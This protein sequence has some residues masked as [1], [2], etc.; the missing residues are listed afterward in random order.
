MKFLFP[1]LSRLEGRYFRRF[2]FPDVGLCNIFA[3]I[4]LNEPSHVLLGFQVNNFVVQR[5]LVMVNSSSTAIQGQMR[6]FC[7]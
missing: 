6:S 3:P 2:I 7:S 5:I 1:F 4:G